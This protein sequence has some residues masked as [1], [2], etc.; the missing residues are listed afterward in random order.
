MTGVEPSFVAECVGAV[1]F[2]I[3]GGWITILAV[4]R[5]VFQRAATSLSAL[6]ATIASQALLLG[7]EFVPTAMRHG[8]WVLGISEAA[9]A[10]LVLFV[11]GILC[12]A[13]L[14]T[15]DGTKFTVLQSYVLYV[16]QLVAGF[17]MG[18]LAWVVAF[19]V[20]YQDG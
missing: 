2:A 12:A 16:L 19:I 11:S 5:L 15:K 20:T 10:L 18:Y 13:I 9:S 3:V 7:V 14:R 8:F 6:L 1:L 17:A 4:S